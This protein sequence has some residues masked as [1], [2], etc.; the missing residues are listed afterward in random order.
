MKFTK[1]D[2]ADLKLQEGKADAIYFDDAM[3]GFGIRLRAG[4]KRVWIAQYRAD[5]QQRRQTLG[6]VRKV[7]LDAAR[8]AAK[9]LFAKVTLGAD[10]QADRAEAK[11]RAALTLGSIADK[12]LAQKK[13]KLRASTFNADKRYL[14]KHWG[15]LRTVPVHKIKLRDVAARVGEIVEAHGATAAARA[16]SALSAVFAW[17]IREGTAD[18][19]PVT[20]TN[21]PT[22]GKESRSRVLTADEVRAIWRA[23]RDDDFGRIVRLLFL[24]AAR[25]DEI[26]GLR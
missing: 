3:P 25:R 14:T 4:G 8:A 20:G 21:N 23:C 24:T 1:Q 12:Y 7:D 15:P 2:V 5:G 9:T 16:R 19:N 10:P 6:D 13:S 17:A 11:V 18:E 26:G 22:K